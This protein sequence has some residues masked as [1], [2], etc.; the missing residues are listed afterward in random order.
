VNFCVPFMPSKWANPWSG[1]L[2]VPVTNCR[3]LAVSSR[4]NERR[5]C[6]NLKFS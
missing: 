3:N 1:T 4:E 5:E 2:D 6:Q